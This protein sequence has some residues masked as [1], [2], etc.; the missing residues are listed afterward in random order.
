MQSGEFVCSVGCKHIAY[1][2]IDLLSRRCPHHPFTL[3]LTPW[4]FSA[5]QSLLEKT[6]QITR[7][8]LEMRRRRE[9]GSGPPVC[10]DFASVSNPLALTP[11]ADTA[12]KQQRLKAWQ[13][14]LTPKTV[15]P[16]LFIIG[17]IF[18]PIGGLLVWGSSQV[19]MIKLD[20]TDCASASAE[21][22]TLPKY[23]YDLRS[24]DSHLSFAAPQ[25]SYTAQPNST[26]RIHF[27]LPAD[28]KPPVFLY[29]QLTNFY[30]NHRRYVQSL[31]TDQLK[32]KAVDVG[33][34]KNGNCKPLAVSWDS[35]SGDR[36]IYPCGLIANSLFNGR[37]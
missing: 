8:S 15:L 19:S 9:G 27:E 23:H 4:H 7:S 36:P 3:N 5:E 32:G 29:Y 20:Y 10:F 33:T 34:L 24:S 17:I 30:Q 31:D 21:F 12:F 26:C 16:T 37:S 35:V 18:A 22:S 14:I 1:A 25:W 11:V 6:V 13:P 2:L 28:L